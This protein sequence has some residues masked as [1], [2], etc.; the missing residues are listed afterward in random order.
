MSVAAAEPTPT[1]NLI[2]IVADDLGWRDLACYG[3]PWHETPNIDRLAREGKRFTSA[4][5]P[6]PICSA[7]RAALLTGKTPARL[8]F[9]F[10]TKNVNDQIPRGHALLA[11]P[12]TLDLPLTETT[13]AELLVNVGYRTGF[14]GKWHLNQHHEG[15]LGWSP[16]HGP[17]AQ[18]FSE[19]DAEFGSHPYEYLKRD[20]RDFGDFAS[21]DFPPDALTDKALA[22]L[23]ENRG[24]PFYL[25]LSHYYVHDP[26]HTRA[27]W[28]YEKYRH[29]LP[30]EVSDD[31]VAYAA[32]IETLDHSIGRM[33]RELDALDLSKNTVVVFTSDN[34]GHPNYAANG[35]L[36]GSKWNLYEG[37]IRVPLIVRWPGVVTANSTCPDPICGFDLFP[38]FRE[39]ASAPT[40]NVERDGRSLVPLLCDQTSPLPPLP[41]VW[42]FPYYHPEKG[43]E[44]APSAIGINDFTTTQTRPH[45]AIR[46]GN[47]KLL[48]FYED[49]V[50]ELYD[51]I[52]DEG[53]QRDLVAHEPIRA[54][55]LRQELDAYLKRVSAR[56]PESDP[57]FLPTPKPAIAP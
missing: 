35:P 12:Y 45:S 54:R 37:G 9:E 43:F 13:I 7:S 50:D 31:R 42:H 2:L 8:G 55:T 21:G 48:H 23:R 20:G 26:I 29:M 53:E 44:R 19:G 18:G 27:R 3:S 47:Y 57:K 32:M 40:D 36:R 17:L 25:Q 14:F 56:M 5:A 22:F 24:R 49:D 41:I 33:L 38:T 15:Y 39:I 51:L 30:A 52:T 10:V 46:M 1:P 28:L 4:Y 34:G 6:A 16:T 11:P